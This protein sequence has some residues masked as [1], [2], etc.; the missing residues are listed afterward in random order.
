MYPVEKHS[1]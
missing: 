1:N